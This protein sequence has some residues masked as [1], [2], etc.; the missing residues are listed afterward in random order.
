MGGTANYWNGMVCAIGHA[1]SCRAD[2][3][4]LRLLFLVN[5]SPD[6]RTPTQSFSQFDELYQPLYQFCLDSASAA[7]SCSLLLAS[8][9]VKLSGDVEFEWCAV[10]GH[11]DAGGCITLTVNLLGVEPGKGDTRAVLVE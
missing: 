2:R 5:L 1:G 11:T 9:V 6:V 4:H 3:L 8:A 7:L 10:D